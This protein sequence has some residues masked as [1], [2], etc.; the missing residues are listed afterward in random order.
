MFELQVPISAKVLFLHPDMVEGQKT[1]ER[2]EGKRERGREGEKRGA[3][4][5]L[6]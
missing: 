5:A 3:R 2:W 6:L 4:V 1:R